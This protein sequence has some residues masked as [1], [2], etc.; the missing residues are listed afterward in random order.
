M[1][2]EQVT[3][4]AAL[5]DDDFIRRGNLRESG[6]TVPELHTETAVEE[7]PVEVEHDDA[8]AVPPKP[9]PP[10]EEKP[11]PE[12]KLDG[13]TK[14]ARQN[15]IQREI[16]EKLEQRRLA[17]EAAAT[18]ERRLAQLRAEIAAE[19]A[20]RTPAK[21]TEPL[22]QGQLVEFAVMPDAPQ[23]ERYV[24]GAVGDQAYLSDLHIFA[25]K[26]SIRQELQQTQAQEA[27]RARMSAWQGRLSDARKANPQFDDEILAAGRMPLT[28]PMWD[29]VID[30]AAG[31]VVLHYLAKNPNDL[32]RIATLPTNHAIREMAK[33]EMRLAAAPSTTG[34]APTVVHSSAPAPTKPVGSTPSVSTSD[35][36]ADSDDESVEAHI[37]RM[38]KREGKSYATRR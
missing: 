21:P 32:Q 19:T 36:V 2:A 38:N 18:E 24:E 13:R 17:S 10:K 3:A 23:R 28:R 12:P 11:A 31:P 15:K 26:T 4:E 34:P 33:I 6:E 9:E 29:Y 35:P 7:A 27:E 37:R 16:D 25:A 8:E 22:S 30:E 5:S 1:N 20:R 14:E